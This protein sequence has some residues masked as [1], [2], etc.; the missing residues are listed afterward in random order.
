[1]G[2]RNS[3]VTVRSVANEVATYLLKN[4]YFLKE[5]VRETAVERGGST[6]C[7]RPVARWWS[8]RRQTKE[9]LIWGRPQEERRGGH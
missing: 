6:S 2:L 5:R 8:G 9:H 4:Y 7:H 1:M 3:R